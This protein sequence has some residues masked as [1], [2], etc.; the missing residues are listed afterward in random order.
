MKKFDGLG[1]AIA[2]IGAAGRLG[3]AGLT[4]RTEVSPVLTLPQVT[5][6]AGFVRTRRIAD[7][8]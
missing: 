2:L 5:D 3:A 6:A 8:K 7:A 4:L 1:K